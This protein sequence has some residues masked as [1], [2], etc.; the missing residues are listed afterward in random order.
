MED[1]LERLRHKRMAE[2]M[3]RI[4][5]QKRKEESEKLKED[6]V[7]LFLKNIMLPDAYQYYKEQLVPQRPHIAS[8]ILEVLQYLVSTENLQS[9]ITKEEIILIDRKLSGIGPN[10]RIKRHGKDFSDLAT[11][12]KKKK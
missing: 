11:E 9:K 10:I 3:E 1:E 4:E 7:E 12:L 5:S 2:M 6:K 8:K